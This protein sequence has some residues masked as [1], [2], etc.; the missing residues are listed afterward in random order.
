MTAEPAPLDEGFRAALLELEEY[1]DGV[2]SERLGE[3]VLPFA[4]AEAAGL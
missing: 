3:L 4:A 2:P 1:L